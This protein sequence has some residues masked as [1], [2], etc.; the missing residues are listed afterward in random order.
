MTD[1]LTRV[2]GALAV[3]LQAEADAESTLQAI[4]KSAGSTVPGVRWAGVCTISKNT[5]ESRAPSG[6]L[7]EELDS[8]QS[9][10][11]DGPCL[12]AL[13]EQ[14]TVRIDDMAT[15]TRWP[16]FAEAA[17][18]RGVHTLLSFQLFVVGT[19]LGALNLYGDRAGAFTDESVAIG[20]VLAQHASVA[21]MAA[22]SEQQFE[23]ALESRDLIGQAKGLLMHRNNIAA[24]HAFRM[25]VEASQETNMKLIDVARWLIQ[26]H[27]SRIS[28]H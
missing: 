5:V 23:S 24:L 8:L 18:D 15:E 22:E 12:D 3:Q 16:Q 4:V 2:F 6:M 10:L 13:R 27:E 9:E 14:R 7:V 1:D 17:R 28:G 25:L 26:E 21:L 20:E 19:N 11:N